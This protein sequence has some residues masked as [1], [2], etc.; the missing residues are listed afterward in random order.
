MIS[1]MNKLTFLIYHKEYEAFLE[2][3]R[4]VGVVHV[5][6]KTSGSPDSPEV[7]DMLALS[8]RYTRIIKSLEK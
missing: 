7:Q 6:E 1:K 4:T 2:R 5:E 8:N 3:L